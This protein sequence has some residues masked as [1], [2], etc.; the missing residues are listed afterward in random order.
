MAKVQ[1]GSSTIE[2]P[3]RIDAE[4]LARRFGGIITDE[5]TMAP[6]P[7]PVLHEDPVRQPRVL[8]PGQIRVGTNI[9]DR[10]KCG[11]LKSLHAK[12]CIGCARK[13]RLGKDK[14]LNP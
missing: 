3:S 8:L 2:V 9:R 11:S 13:W 1:I 12:Q 14:L 4:R 6:S 10:C 7:P 5:R